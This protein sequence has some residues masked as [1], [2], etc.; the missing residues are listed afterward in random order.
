MTEPEVVEWLG[1]TGKTDGKILLPDITTAMADL[2]VPHTEEE[3]VTTFMV[4]LRAWKESLIAQMLF[5][6]EQESGE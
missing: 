4:F 2:P 5:D 1:L 3:Q 6:A